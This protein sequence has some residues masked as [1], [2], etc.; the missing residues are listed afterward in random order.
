[1]LLLEVGDQ[2][3]HLIS[4]PASFFK[5]L[6]QGSRQAM[7]NEKGGEGFSSSDVAGVGRQHQVDPEEFFCGVCVTPLTSRSVAVLGILYS[8]TVNERLE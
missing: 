8:L 3:P 4:A 2:L 1:M 7:V 5:G 6:P